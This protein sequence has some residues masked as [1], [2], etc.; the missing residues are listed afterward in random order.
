MSVETAKTKSCPNCGHKITL[1]AW[2]IPVKHQ[3]D[4]YMDAIE[5]AK[6]KFEQIS[7]ECDEKDNQG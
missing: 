1:N 5:R 3:D 2:G 6:V 7:K 4:D